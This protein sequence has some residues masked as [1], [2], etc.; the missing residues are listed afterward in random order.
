MTFLPSPLFHSFI[1]SLIHNWKKIFDLY[2]ERNVELL[3]PLSNSIL[4]ELYKL[5]SRKKRAVKDGQPTKKTHSCTQWTVESDFFVSLSFW[6]V[7]GLL[8]GGRRAPV[9]LL[10]GV[11]GVGE[12]ICSSISRFGKCLVG[13]LSGGLA[14]KV[15]KGQWNTLFLSSRIARRAT[16]GATVTLRCKK[17]DISFLSTPLGINGVLAEC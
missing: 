8:S 11:A 13:V 12:H 7:G 6:L 9:L 14:I 1:S 5:C 16:A 3:S 4:L 15:V 2:I 17:R 10:M